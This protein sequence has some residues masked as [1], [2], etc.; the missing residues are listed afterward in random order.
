VLIFG[1]GSG[2]LS[3]GGNFLEII[4]GDKLKGPKGDKT[5]TAA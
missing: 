1:A 5:I 3:G 2:T 4:G